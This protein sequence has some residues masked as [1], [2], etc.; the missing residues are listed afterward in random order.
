MWHSF[1][2]AKLAIIPHST[3][4]F[5]VFYLPAVKFIGNTHEEADSPTFQSIATANHRLTDCWGAEDHC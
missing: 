3:K 4:L 1:P 2:G 5:D